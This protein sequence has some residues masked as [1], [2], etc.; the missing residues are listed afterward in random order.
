MV[1]DSFGSGLQHCLDDTVHAVSVF[2]G[3]SGIL[4]NIHPTQ[5]LPWLFFLCIQ[6]ILSTEGFIVTACAQAKAS[7]S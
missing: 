1:P 4:G 5:V 3:Q 2:Q 6:S 7:A